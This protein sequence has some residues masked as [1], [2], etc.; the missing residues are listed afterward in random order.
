MP[1]NRIEQLR[2]IL[3]TM[4]LSEEVELSGDERKEVQKVARI[5]LRSLLGLKVE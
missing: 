3:T 4:K 2:D 1:D 5:Y